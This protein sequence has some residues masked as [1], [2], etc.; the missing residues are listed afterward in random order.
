MIIQGINAMKNYILTGLLCV[1]VF[2]FAHA[3]EAE[4]HAEQSQAVVKTFF[5]RLKAELGQAMKAGG[6]V[7]AIEVCNTAAPQIARELSAKH[8]M[9]VARTSLKIRN[10]ANAPDAWETA[11]L[12]KFEQRRAAGEDPATMVYHEVVESDGKKQ[13]R[14][15]KAI[16]M[17]P[18]DKMPCLKCHGETIDAAIVSKLDELYPQD[19][20][21][22]YKPGQIRGAFTLSKTLD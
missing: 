21:R 15:M 17:P 2:S 8:G 12:K 11:V 18:M 16:G 6:P 22:G 5:G 14:F 9:R 19:Q 3:G 4:R 10:P 20:A 7:N 13:F 1:L